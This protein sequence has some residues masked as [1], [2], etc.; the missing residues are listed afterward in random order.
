MAL[1]MAAARQ[2]SRTSYD[3]KGCVPFHRQIYITHH[4]AC[5]FMRFSRRTNLVRSSAC[6]AAS[7]S[8]RRL[9]LFVRT[10]CEKQN[11]LRPRHAY[12]CDFNANESTPI[13]TGRSETFNVV[14]SL[15]KYRFRV[16][17]RTAL[18]LFLLVLRTSTY[19]Y[20]TV[21]NLPSNKRAAGARAAGHSHT[22]LKGYNAYIPIYGLIADNKR[23]KSLSSRE[24]YY[25]KSPQRFQTIMFLKLDFRLLTEQWIL[26]S[27]VSATLQVNEV[28]T[29]MCAGEW[30]ARSQCRRYIFI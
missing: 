9:R 17:C 24:Q 23:E 25:C 2:S 4:C 28:R 8:A 26:K 22:S 29:C 14:W 1:S 10:P 12:G 5:F 3:Y 7:H 16:E 18:I 13:P 15:L 20:I 19:C 11:N 27:L 6:N 30:P 21:K